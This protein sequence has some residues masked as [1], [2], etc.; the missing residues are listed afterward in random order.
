MVSPTD[1]RSPYACMHANFL[2]HSGSTNG[3][4]MPG[5]IVQ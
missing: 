2:T 3:A 4:W 1:P 5:G